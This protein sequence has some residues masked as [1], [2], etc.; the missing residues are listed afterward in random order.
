MPK[1][2][3]FTISTLAVFSFLLNRNKIIKK[4]LC[5]WLKIKILK[6]KEER[7]LTKML[8]Y[9]LIHFTFIVARSYLL[10]LMDAIP[11]FML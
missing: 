3:I 2:F 6:K 1:I 9:N 11:L 10:F 7:E 5:F 8:C 4:K